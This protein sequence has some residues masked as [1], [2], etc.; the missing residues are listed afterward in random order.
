MLLPLHSLLVVGRQYRV[1]EGG[2]DLIAL[3]T[4]WFGVHR[5]GVLHQVRVFLYSPEL[6]L[7][8]RI[9]QV[10]GLVLSN[11]PSKE[12]Q[13]SMLSNLAVSSKEFKQPK[14]PIEPKPP[15][16]TSTTYSTNI[17]SLLRCQTRRCPT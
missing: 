2:A 15:T 17:E 1:H 14:E 16:A 4:V 11:L 5:E 12:W 7:S 3:L 13:L 8:R 9:R 6:A 10:S